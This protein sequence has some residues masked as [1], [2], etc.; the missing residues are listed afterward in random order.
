MN[1][2]HKEVVIVELFS[3]YLSAIVGTYPH[4]HNSIKSM[5]VC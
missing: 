5:L 1:H 2:C 3:I 4:L